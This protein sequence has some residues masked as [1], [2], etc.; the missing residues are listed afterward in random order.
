MQTAVAYLIVAAAAA[1][2]LRSLLPRLKPVRVKA[3]RQSSGGCDNC[4]CGR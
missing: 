2:S 1:W 4:D 3:K